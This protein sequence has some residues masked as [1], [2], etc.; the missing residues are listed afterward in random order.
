[1]QR[2]LQVVRQSGARDLGPPSHAGGPL[3]LYK[4]PQSMHHR[5]GSRYSR[6]LMVDNALQGPIAKNGSQSATITA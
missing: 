6:D 4:T 3:L 5:T 2:R 1:M